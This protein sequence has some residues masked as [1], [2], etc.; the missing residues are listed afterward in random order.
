M[1]AQNK[2]ISKVYD[3]NSRRDSISEEILIVAVDDISVDF[4]VYHRESSQKSTLTINIVS[5]GDSK[6][7][8]RATAY[9]SENAIDCDSELC[10][11][12]IILGTGTVD[13][14]PTLEINHNEVSAKHSFK[15]TY[16]NNRALA[17][18]RTRGLSEEEILQLYLKRYFRFDISESIQESRVIYAQR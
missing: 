12:A 3:L 11:R 10:I 17:Y 16:I 9:I 6:C 15:S 7:T 14:T 4:S 18:L 8:V 2:T 13:A 5:L 1:K